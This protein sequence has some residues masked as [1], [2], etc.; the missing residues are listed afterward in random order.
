MSKQNVKLGGG[1][2][3]RGFTLVELLVVIAIIGILIALLLPAVQAAREAAR[4][5]QCTNHLKQMGL[6]IHNFHDSQRG[7]PPACVGSIEQHGLWGR[8]YNSPSLFILLFPY[9]EQNALYEIV[10]RIGWGY[11]WNEATWAHPYA[12]GAAQNSANSPLTDSEKQGFYSVPYMKCPSRRSTGVGSIRS[13]ASGDFGAAGNPSG[14]PTGDYAY[15]VSI[16]DNTNTP[17]NPGTEYWWWQTCPTTLQHFVSHRG[18]FRVATQTVLG[19]AAASAATWRPRDT[20][21]RMTDGTSNQIMI[22]EKHINISLLGQC[23]FTT[24]DRGRCTHIGDCTYFVTGDRRG[25]ATSRVT[26]WIYPALRHPIARPNDHPHDSGSDWTPNF[27]SWHPGVCNFVFGDGSV[28]ALSVTTS[29]DT[30]RA[31]GNVSSGRSVSF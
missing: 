14:G 10:G 17:T 30:L 13:N 31:L 9:A 21:S 7:L 16:P 28:Q 24:M 20:I 12:A 4:R 5:M 3:L 2:N 29:P 25:V 19:S 26:E 1:G 15:V 8:G 27:G 6:A 11:E 23:N 22:G 18:P